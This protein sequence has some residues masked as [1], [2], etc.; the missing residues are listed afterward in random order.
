MPVRT[1]VWHIY[2]CPPIDEW[3][4]VVGIEEHVTMLGER[5]EEIGDIE[6]FVLLFEKA[7]RAVADLTSREGDGA[8]VVSALPDVELR[9]MQPFFLVKQQ[10]NG[11]TFIASTVELPW[12][13]P[14]ERLPGDDFQPSQHPYA[15]AYITHIRD[16]ERRVIER[17]RGSPIYLGQPRRRG[18]PSSE[19]RRLTSLPA[20]CWKVSTGPGRRV[21]GNCGPW[22]APG[23]S[24]TS[25]APG[26]GPHS[27]VPTSWR[28]VS[29]L[30]PRQVFR[31]KVTTHTQSWLTL[32]RPP[33]APRFPRQQGASTSTDGMAATGPMIPMV[34]H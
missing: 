27:S 8:W 25:Q 18:L 30:I 11:K 12:L 9:E 10:N 5:A 31:S 19:P 26:N 20:R 29:R 32:S 4:G 22:N 21:C 16:V 34:L 2:E 33:T 14:F 24:T 1:T 3:Q 13:A 15:K 6:G 28:A 7:V 17:R 23:C